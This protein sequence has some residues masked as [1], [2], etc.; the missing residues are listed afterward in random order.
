MKAL[1]ITALLLVLLLAGCS[2]FVPSTRENTAAHK[3]ADNAST[4]ANAEF[5]GTVQYDPEPT[6]EVID[7]GKKG[8]T[9]RITPQPRVVETKAVSVAAGKAAIHEDATTVNS[10][11]IPLGVKLILLAI[12]IVGVIFAL[13][14]AYNAIRATAIGQAIGKGDAFLANR[15]RSYRARASD[16]SATTDDKAFYASEIAELES[17]RARLA[18]EK[19]PK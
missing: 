16:S 14:W 10:V 18:Q 7:A 8:T 12:G 3:V 4:K 9:V 17:E 6:V 1:H 11:N 19:M 13:K 2:T 15:I 5:V